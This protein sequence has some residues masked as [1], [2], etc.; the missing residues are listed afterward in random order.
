MSM[1]SLSFFGCPTKI[2]MGVGAVETLSRGLLQA[3]PPAT[4]AAVVRHATL[5]RERVLSCT[6]GA[7]AA[8][9][10]EGGPGSPAV[11]IVG[12]VLRGLER[13]GSHSLEADGVAGTAR[14][15]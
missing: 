8:S 10:R 2:Y 13:L 5:P 6:L 9:I 3:L 15:S 1:N 11:I 14:R 7:L 12:D 4:P